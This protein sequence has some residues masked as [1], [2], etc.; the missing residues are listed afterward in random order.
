M[1]RIVVDGS[2]GTVEW[3]LNLEGEMPARDYYL[4]LEVS[5]QAKIL[6]LFRIFADRGLIHNREKFKKLGNK[7]KGEG[8][9]LWEFKSFQNRFLG[10]Y[11]PGGRFIIVH[12][13]RKKGDDLRPPDIEKTVRA[14]Q[15]ND[16]KEKG[17]Y[18]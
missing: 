10:D 7:A 14:L 15:E 16:R 3:G 9:E 6:S 8:A 5:D 11:R 2:W 18:P 1:T 17:N 4:H 13:V 12:S